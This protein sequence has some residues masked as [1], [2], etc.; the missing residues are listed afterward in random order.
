M[1]LLENKIPPPIVAL[2]FGLAMWFTA[3]LG[4]QFN[5]PLWLARALTGG[6]LI[7]GLMIPI[8]G[9]IAFRK[10]Q[11]T[12]NP[13]KPEQASTL[14][15]NGVFRLSRN[16]M[17]LGMSLV[18]LAWAISLMNVAAIL[19]V[20]CFMLYIDRF[21]IRP[22]ERALVANFGEEFEAYR[23]SVRRWL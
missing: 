13:L 22:E 4:F 16:P 8:A 18:L 11:T 1:A 14:V 2:L 17:Y 23:H 15:T 12:I 6:C 5:L 19:L 3:G 7:I 21:Q 9:S 10:A 20:P